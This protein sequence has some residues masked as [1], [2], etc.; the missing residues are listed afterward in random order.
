MDVEDLDQCGVT[1]STGMRVL[2]LAF[3]MDCTGSMGSYIQQARQNIKAIAEDIVHLEKVSL[4]LALVEYRDHPPQDA[5]FVTRV[6]NFT[7]SV[8]D[9]KNRLDSC[10][11]KG[12][13][14]TP[15]AVADALFE[16]QR[17][18]WRS[19]AT[20][21]C[22]LISDAPPHGLGCGG[23]AFPAGCPCGLDPMKTGRSLAEKGVTIYV[24]GCEPS[25]TPYRDWFT[26]L[27]HLT[28]GQYVPLASATTLPQIIVGGA[29][30]EMSLQNLMQDVESEISNFDLNSLADGRVSQ[31]QVVQ[32]V[33][34]K[35]RHRGAKSK[36]LVSS[37][38]EL[39][40]PSSKALELFEKGSMAEVRL[41]L[42]R[43]GG[44]CSSS[45]A[46]S[47]TAGAEYRA[48]EKDVSYEQAA[49][50]VQRSLMS[51]GLKK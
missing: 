35:L 22:V 51:F 37:Q 9:M 29:Q 31:T 40:G 11:A 12:G 21:I 2:D 41:A 36:H 14:D 27:A 47:A 20:K 10:S 39:S 24:V 13:G 33:F 7:S 26:A 15:E 23:D 50:L 17:L 32:T 30:E 6:L 3:A 34:D 8:Q 38:G 46:S 42:D 18:S 16:V 48:V 1:A 19:N 45:T 28:G 49:R 25:I 44:S 4:N 43:S 5:T